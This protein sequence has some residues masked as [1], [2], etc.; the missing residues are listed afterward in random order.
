MSGVKR[1][2]YKQSAARHGMHNLVVAS[3][4]V[5]AQLAGLTLLSLAVGIGYHHFAHGNSGVL[6]TH[7]AGGALVALV[8]MGYAARRQ[9]YSIEGYLSG[10]GRPSRL[11]MKWNVAF[12]TLACF[13]FLTKT[14]ADFSRGWIVLFYGSGLIFVLALDVVTRLLVARGLSSGAIPPRRIM[15][16]GT[17]AEI[18]AFALRI[19][20][21]EEQGITSTVTVVSSLALPAESVVGDEALVARLL[22]QGVAKA[23]ALLPDDV[24]MLSRWSERNLI[25][26]CIAAFSDLP[27]A[28]RIDGGVFLDGLDKVDI[29]HFGN[30]ATVSLSGPPLSPFEVV[31]K[32]GCDFVGAAL[33]LI[34]GLPI[35]AAIAI[36]IKLDS[37]GPVFFRQRRLGFNQQP[38]NIWKFR[39]MSVMDNGDVIHQAAA[40]D[41]RITRVGRFLRRTNLDELP[42]LLNVVQGAMSLVG[43]RPHA[44][45]HDR[46]WEKR[47]KRYPRRL[48]VKPGIT[49]WAQVNGFRGELD[50]VEKLDGRVKHDLYY[51]DHWSMAFDVYILVMTL[52]SR[53]AFR[54]AR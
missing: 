17:R 7:A 8:F 19:A 31:V 24:V 10:A 34:A 28:I 40:D 48:N 27:V 29:G 33:L 39:T 47:V 15:L 46:D 18:D 25:L 4:V 50:S 35:F 30:A 49:G 51:I 53:R 38:F 2:A 23:R 32:R 1:I 45:A 37:A 6:A 5:F 22:D 43:P 42:Q 52:F 9:D 14:T 20:T 12:M 26:R 36:A 44:V 16:I 21:D 11:F 41:V 13:A 54:N 3:A